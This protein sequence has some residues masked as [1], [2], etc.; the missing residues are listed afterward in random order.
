[1]HP[2]HRRRAATLLTA[3]ALGAATAT[4][5]AATTDSPAGAHTGAAPTSAALAAASGPSSA[6]TRADASR[7]T[8]DGRVLAISLDGL[9]PTALTR[10]GRAGTPHL[11]RLM[12]Q[13]ASTLNARTQVE[14]TVTLP[15][16]TSMITGRR[17]SASHGGHG[18]T[19]NTDRPGSTVQNAS[20]DAGIA[21]VFNV[22]HAAGGK[23]A[24]FSTKTK[25]SI[26]DRS[27]PGAVNRS[28][29]REERDAAL[30]RVLRRDL[31]RH[32]RAFTFLHLGLADHTGHAQKWMSPAYLTA[33]RTLDRLLG[34]VLDTIKEKPRLSDVRIV[35][36]ADHGGVPGTTGHGNATKRDDYRVPFLV[37]GP[38]VDRGN[39][40]AMNAKVRRDPGKDRPRFGGKQPVRN[41]ELANVA[42]DLL[43]LRAVPDSK[44]NRKQNLAWTD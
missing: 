36:T 3:L 31:V 33:V 43:G 42:T 35:L 20:G 29:I 14:R 30:V 16:H 37:W 7:A 8:P 10:L 38:G 39:L 13:G 27:W 21:S 41:G 24:L 15:N 6:T 1:M 12:R 4:A 18:V 2:T 17:I 44:W 32:D 34:T 25:F 23:T 22:V 11:H 19:W 26:F 28:V 40:Y 5:C 9:N